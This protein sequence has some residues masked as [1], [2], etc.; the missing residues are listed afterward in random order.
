[1][2]TY[3]AALSGTSVF[4]LDIGDLVEEAYERSGLELKSSY[5]LKT[6]RRSINLLTLEWQNRGLDIWVVDKVAIGP[7]VEDQSDYDV[8]LGTVDVLDVSWS[9]ATVDY[10]LRKINQRSYASI[11]MKGTSGRPDRFWFQP[12]E[13][14]DATGGV[15][16]QSKIS[17]YPV[18]NASYTSGYTVNLWRTRRIEDTGNYA[19]NTIEVPSVYLPVLASGLAYRIAMKHPEASARLP[20]LKSDYDEQLAIVL[21]QSAPNDSN[22]QMVMS[23]PQQVQG[24]VQ[25]MKMPDRR[26]SIPRSSSRRGF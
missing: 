4:N 3:D 1:M 10:M 14:M 26:S 19:S 24:N 6:S 9:S 7:A 2:P 17:V 11:M 13:V 22:T 16:R 5:D 18:P 25:P 12:I 23:Q 21:S 20:L 15:D 8:P